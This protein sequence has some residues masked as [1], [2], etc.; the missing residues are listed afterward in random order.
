MSRFNLDFRESKPKFLS[1]NSFPTMAE[2]T[3]VTSL[4]LMWKVRNGSDRKG[5]VGRERFAQLSS[6]VAFPLPT[7]PLVVGRM[8][9]AAAATQPICS[10][11][12][13]VGP[14]GHFVYRSVGTAQAESST[15]LPPV[16]RGRVRAA[17]AT[18][19][20]S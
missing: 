18:V 15:S 6:E 9:I 14:G 4:Y 3:S 5:A 16:Y 12:Q 20:V 2:I 7:V 13:S 17:R 19:A 8:S 10:G 11:S 1:P